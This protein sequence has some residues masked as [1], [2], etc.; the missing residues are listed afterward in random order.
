[1]HSP[2]DHFFGSADLTPYVDAASDTN[3]WS[4]DRVAMTVRA[5]VFIEGICA[6]LD[7]VSVGWQWASKTPISQ[8]KGS[9]FGEVGILGEEL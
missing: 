3:S 8:G 1:M 2:R 6:T 7:M 9:A 4:W 5:R